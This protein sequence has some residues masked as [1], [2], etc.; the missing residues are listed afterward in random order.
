MKASPAP[1]SEPSKMLAHASK[2]RYTARIGNTP[3]EAA[4]LSKQHSRQ[5]KDLALLDSQ[6]TCSCLAS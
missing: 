3:A 2:G 1:N 5:A 4:T 6:L